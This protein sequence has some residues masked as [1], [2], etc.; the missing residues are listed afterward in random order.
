[1][2]ERTSYLSGNKDRN[3]FEIRTRMLEIAQEY[4]ETQYKANMEFARKMWMDQMSAGS[5]T[6]ADADKFLPK[7]YSFEEIIKKA[8]DLYGFVQKK[9]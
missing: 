3:P 5:A 6:L 8:S 4:L 7:M 2:R 9:D 1:M